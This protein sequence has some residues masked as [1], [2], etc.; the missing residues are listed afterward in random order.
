MTSSPSDSR[1]TYIARFGG[2]ADSQELV[3]WCREYDG[4]FERRSC[5]ERQRGGGRPGSWAPRTGGGPFP[6]E[7]E[8]S[9]LSWPLGVPRPKAVSRGKWPRQA[10]AMLSGAT[11]VKFV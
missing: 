11:G 2:H 7:S 6:M 5:Q 4:D 9:E 10:S 1:G 3:W 8:E